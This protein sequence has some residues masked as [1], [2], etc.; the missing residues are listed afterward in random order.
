MKSYSAGT[1]GPTAA[2]ELIARDSR[3]WHDE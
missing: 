2:V 1:D 3:S